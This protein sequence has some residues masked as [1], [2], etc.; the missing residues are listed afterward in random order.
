MPDS[1]SIAFFLR[2]L[3]E[4]FQIFRQRFDA[5]VGAVSSHNPEQKVEG[6]R[7]AL[8]ALNDLKSAMSSKD[9]PT[10]IAPLEA[11]L[12]WY[13]QNSKHN[14]AGH[15]L[16]NTIIAVSPA[17]QSQAWDLAS[18]TGAEPIDF[19]A[20]FNRFY[21]ESRL[22]ELFEELVRQLQ[23]IVDSGEVD[24]LKVLRA[25]ERAAATIRKNIRGS[26][27]STAGTWEF[28]VTL[29]RNYLWELLSGIPALGSLLKSV[30]KTMD[31]LDS[32][33]A[34]VHDEMRKELRSQISADLPMLEYK[35]KALPGSHEGSS[36]NP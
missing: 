35:P 9:Q 28:T 8:A 13:I 11:K 25:L 10:W 12:H 24:S 7:A 19:D 20:V 1:E 4:R 22:A 36:E 30:R 6:C 15:V 33:M 21:K 16:M 26:Y 14:D 27:F 3:T 5:L 18:P 2:F 23:Q 29:F 17:I 34:R 32:E 31:D